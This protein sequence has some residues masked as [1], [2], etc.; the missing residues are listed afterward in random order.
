LQALGLV[1]FEVLTLHL[2]GCEK[3]VL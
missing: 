2:V 1:V 3:I